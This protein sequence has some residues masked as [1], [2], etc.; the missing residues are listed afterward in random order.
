M[1]HSVQA[2]LT[3]TLLHF[4][5]LARSLLLGR[6]RLL[7][8]FS[9]PLPPPLLLDRALPSLASQMGRRARNTPFV[10]RH[11]SA[12]QVGHRERFSRQPQK[13]VTASRLSASK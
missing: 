6:L 12:V 9:A 4:A 2:M 13:A 10:L 8:C 7:G 1:F 5:A 3:S 11:V